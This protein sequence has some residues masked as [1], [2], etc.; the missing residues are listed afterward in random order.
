[1]KKSVKITTF[2]RFALQRIKL[3]EAELSSAP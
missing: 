2:Y 1:M 3:A